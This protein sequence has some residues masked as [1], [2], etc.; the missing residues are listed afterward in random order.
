MRTLVPHTQSREGV[1]FNQAPRPLGVR[2]GRSSEVVG[3]DIFTEYAFASVTLP[4]GISRVTVRD[5]VAVALGVPVAGVSVARV[6]AS[7]AASLSLYTASFDASVASD[8]SLSTAFARASN[9][10]AASVR[11]LGYG[12]PKRRLMLADT[13]RFNVT[14]GSPE[15]LDDLWRRYARGDGNSSVAR[16]LGAMG[17]N[18]EGATVVF[19]DARASVT[20]RVAPRNSSDDVLQR[21]F[22]D[23][24][25]EM[26]SG[27][28][29]PGVSVHLA[30]AIPAGASTANGI[31]TRSLVV[32]STA[33]A[34][35]FTAYVVCSRALTRRDRTKRRHALPLN[36]KTR[37]L[38]L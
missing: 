34:L 17:L 24:T 12:A 38:I 26:L 28:M 25:L 33:P 22:N 5:A 3:P 8:D 6:G 15:A 31:D 18:G 27:L 30:A 20:T 10:S 7:V 9:V 4:I 11:L 32:L 2:S 16:E 23:T 1:P 29:P 13:A 14:V 21:V 19:Q 37:K 35:A 36:T